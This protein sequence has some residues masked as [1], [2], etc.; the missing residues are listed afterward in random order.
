MYLCTLQ[1]FGSQNFT[2][3]NFHAPFLHNFDILEFLLLK[4]RP[5]K[6]E[7]LDCPKPN[8]MALHT[9]ASNYLCIQENDA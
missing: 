2:Y 6:K 4:K 7:L 5:V 8:R 3:M 1:V 9:Y